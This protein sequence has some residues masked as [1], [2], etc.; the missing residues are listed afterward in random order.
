M[1]NFIKMMLFIAI[2]GA[3]T[4]T[5][6]AS[7]AATA[8]EVPLTTDIDIEEEVQGVSFQWASDFPSFNGTIIDIQPYY[9]DTSETPIA[10][11]R[12]FFVVV[13][14]ENMDM[15][16]RVSFLVDHESVV[17][18]E[19]LE[20]GM[21]IAVIFDINKSLMVVS[22]GILN[23]R[24]LA[25]GNTG[26]TI[27]RFNQSDIF[28]L[29]DTR[30]G[31]LGSDSNLFIHIN[32]E[33]EI[34][35]QDGTP[36]DGDLIELE[37]RIFAFTAE[38][39]M[40]SYPGQTSPDKIVILFEQAE[41]PL[42]ELTQEDLD[43]MWD[44]MFDPETVQV[45]VNSEAID[46]PTPFINRE[47]GFVMVPVAY[48]AEALGYPVVGEGEALIVGHGTTFTIGVDE[49]F[50]ARMAP[51]QLGAAPQL[52][53]D[54]IFVPLHFFGHVFPEGSYVADGHIFITSAEFWD[55]MGD[56]DHY[57]PGS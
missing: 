23:A 1:K 13:E 30:G 51:I 20:I 16:P 57:Y 24:A 11:D 45:F 10:I 9:H 56:T 46:M 12:D 38:Y 33:T 25:L 37:N 55:E 14:D 50:F 35:F 29:P 49:Y 8:T 53:D 6:C 4:L 52:H 41:H 31:F 48:I 22:D 32:A 54:N 21:E 28:Q 18:E 44:N 34:I 27:D 36:F 19:N 5:A 26:L 42:L 40:W 43:L 3:I 2:V 47:D 39:V 17:L 15:Y 7:T